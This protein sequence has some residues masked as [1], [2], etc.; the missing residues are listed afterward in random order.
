VH[1]LSKTGIT[2]S[3]SRLPG[4]ET[5]GNTLVVNQ[6]VGITG[7][8]RGRA[9]VYVSYE[10]GYPI[11]RDLDVLRIGASRPVTLAKFS[12][13]GEELAGSTI[14][15]GPNGRLWD[16]W[17]DGDGS[18][19]QLFVRASNVNGAD[20]GKTVHVALPKGTQFVFKVYASAQASRVDLV[21]LLTRGGHTA[22]YA[23][24]SLL[25]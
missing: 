12:I 7:R 3:A 1:R 2:G 23:T 17:I 22:Y 20:W 13:G 24:Q 18:A 15:A 10:S 14:T 16:A 9:G 19:P 11:A 21:V 8:G 4:S 5:G 6:R 25:P